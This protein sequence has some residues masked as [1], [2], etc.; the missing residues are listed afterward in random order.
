VHDDPITSSSHSSPSGP[1]DPGEVDVVGIGNALVDVISHGTDELIES[2]GVTKGAM[3]L[4]DEDRAGEIYRS[5]G[6]AVEISGGSAANTIVG[7]AALG[8]TARYIGKVRDDQLGGVFVHDIRATGVRYDTPL[9][10]EGPSTGCCL[11]LVTPD[12][13]RTMS[14]YLGASVHLGAADVDP[15]AIRRGRV[16]Y[17]EGYLFDPPE[18]QDAFRMAAGHAREAGRTVSLTLSDSF[19]VERHRAAFVD[20]VEHHIDLVF[21]NEAEILALYEVSSFDEAVERVR[22]H[23]VVAA[24]TRSERGS[25]IV[26]ADDVIEVPAQPVERLVDTTGAGDL[27]AAGFLHGF[28]RGMDLDVC[29]ALG[30]VAAAEV[31]SHVGARPEADLREL[32]S[33]LLG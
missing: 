19:C 6:P 16:L 3:T 10:S 27:Y 15:E 11:V 18:A 28:S 24:L 4:I 9:A 7:V 22:G 26:S 20:L 29:G 30:S 12:A 1:D 32:A 13:Q 25:V 23:G 21:A 17:L 8:G 14:T 5:T 31:I 2:L 33:H